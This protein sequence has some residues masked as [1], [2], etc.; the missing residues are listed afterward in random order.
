VTRIDEH[1]NSNTSGRIN[2]RSVFVYSGLK[3]DERVDN[4]MLLLVF[5]SVS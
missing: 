2:S 4:A 3:L 1:P 5:S